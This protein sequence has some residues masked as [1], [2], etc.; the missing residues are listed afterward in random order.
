MAE[1][2]VKTAPSSTSAGAH[3]GS[4]GLVP[5]PAEQV[6]GVKA[7]RRSCFLLGVSLPGRDP[8]ASDPT[9]EQEACVLAAFPHPR[10][11]E[12]RTLLAGS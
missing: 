3:R 7:G 10:G 12:A 1:P 6:V 9:R 2:R 4:T 8:S 11:A 5:G